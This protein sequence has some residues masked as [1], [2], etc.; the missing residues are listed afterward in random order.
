VTVADARPD[1]E[2]R[3]RHRTL[4]REAVL[5]AALELIDEQG[6]Q[7]LTMRALG[8]RLG[9]EAMTLYHW[10]PS[11][12]A[13]LEGVLEIVI[14]GLFDDPQRAVG[15]QD[16]WQEM[17]VRLAH[18]TRRMAMAHPALFPLIA[19]SPPAAP[20]VRPPLRSLRWVDHFLVELT[21]RGFTD[22]AAIECYR[23]FTHFLVG[24]LLLE[25]SSTGVMDQLAG[26]DESALDARYAEQ[27]RDFPTLARLA[28]RLRE[29]HSAAE[30]ETGLADLIER[31]IERC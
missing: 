26:L 20:W 8:A 29:D 16:P 3:P 21:A 6:L 27:L 4:T 14:D 17:L 5:I 13:L 22:A 1:K 25:V 31:I 28:P 12:A 24:S 19:T 18:A 11:R 9:V 30:F 2:S 23:A 10:V 15:P 7:R